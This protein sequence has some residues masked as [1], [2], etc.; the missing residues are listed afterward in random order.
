MQPN[1][2][3]GYGNFAAFFGIYGLDD[4]AR[5][6]YEHAF[7]LSPKDPLRSFWRGDYGA[8][9]FVA[10]QYE[11]CIENAREGPRDSP[12]FATLM[13]QEA[14]SFGMLGQIEEASASMERMLHK[15]PD[16]TIIQV[17][18]M[19]PIRYEDDWER[20]LGSGPVD[21]RF[22]GCFAV[23]K[24]SGDHVRSFLANRRPDGAP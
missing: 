18:N 2:T 24:T 15:M 4:Q 19:V 6:S 12:G 22:A 17:R 1:L 13:R 8:G 10:K 7:S 14:T 21:F 5:D 11:A 3:A 9:L 16:L 20:W 23:R